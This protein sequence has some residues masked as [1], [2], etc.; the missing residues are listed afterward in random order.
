VVSAGTDE[1]TS[2]IPQPVNRPA[3]SRRLDIVRKEAARI[4][5]FILFSL[6]VQGMERHSQGFVTLLKAT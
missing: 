6:Y 2:P 1:F 5:S 3:L 4:S